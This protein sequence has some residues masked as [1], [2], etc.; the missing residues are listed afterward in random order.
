MEQ[1]CKYQ[2]PEHVEIEMR[3]PCNCFAKA[4]A[5]RAL[6]AKGPQGRGATRAKLYSSGTHHRGLRLW[7]VRQIRAVPLPL[8]GLR[9]C[10]ALKLLEIK[11][12]RHDVEMLHRAR[13]VVPFKLIPSH[14][15]EVAAL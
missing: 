11:L 4:T 10:G 13:G 1:V 12:A 3:G 14:E 5:V 15:M 8:A 9:L 6:G 7:A 2:K